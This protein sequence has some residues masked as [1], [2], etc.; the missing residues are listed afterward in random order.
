MAR[1]VAFCHCDRCGK[2]FYVENND[3]WNG[4]EVK[5]WEGWMRRINKQCPECR[6]ETGEELNLKQP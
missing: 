1:G 2:D 3:L 5:A 6:E 4:R